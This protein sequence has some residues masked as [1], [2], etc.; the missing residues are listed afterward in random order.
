[1]SSVFWLEGHAKQGDAATGDIAAHGVDDFVGHA[2][3]ARL[4]DLDDR[5]ND[6]RRRGAL[7]AILVSAS[8]SF[9]KQEPP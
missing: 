9:G 2:P 7:R 8:V 1:M 5:F 3:L 4:V 6:A